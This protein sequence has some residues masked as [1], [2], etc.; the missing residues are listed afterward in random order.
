MATIKD[1]AALAGISYTTVSHVLNKTRPVSEPVRLK[2]EAAIA[3]LDYVPSAVARSL[4]ARSTATIG[5]LVPSSVNP[6][7][8]ELAR[9]I[10][11]GCERNGYCVILCNSDDD[12]RKQRNYLRVLLEKR[13]DGLIVASVGEERDLLES[14]AAVRTPMVMV[15]RALAG[16]DADL[17]RIDHELGAFLAT[18]HLLELGHTDIACIG[19]PADTG[20]SQLRV[21]GFRRAMA[22]AGHE[23]D[24][25]RVVH[26]D[27]TSPGGYRAAAQVL[28]GERPTAIFAGNDMIG[29]GVLRAA[30]E[31]AVDVPG[32]LSVIG[33]DD[34]ELSR[35]VYPPLTTVGQS[36]RELG[37]SAA[38]LLLSRIA[39]P[40][41][42]G[43]EQRIVAPRIVPR[44]STG[45]CPDLFNDYR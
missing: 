28:D 10:E 32:Q 12:P 42:E 19:G 26:C 16:I 5:L 40:R 23:V 15:D 27:F 22:E 38:Q 29:F 39:V 4:K 30:A 35:Y 13:I 36:I 8:A 31:R 21:S 41:R 37:D 9:G 7:F 44:Q 34:I 14:L 45:P 2:V 33:F 25:R 43:C 20:V 17:V 1:V 6:Y 11:D 3:E 18:R 24:D